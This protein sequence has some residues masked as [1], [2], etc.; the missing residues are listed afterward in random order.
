MT[1]GELVNLLRQFEPEWPVDVCA[2]IPLRDL[3]WHV[4]PG[5]VQEV[6]HVKEIP[7]DRVMI[8]TKF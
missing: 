2:M 6:D 5:G 3:G 1:V 7:G 4:D 8:V